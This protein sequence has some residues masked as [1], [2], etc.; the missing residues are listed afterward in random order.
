LTALV[1]LSLLLIPARACDD[2]PT[3]V[4]YD[5]PLA[6]QHGIDAERLAEA[7]LSAERSDRVNSLLVERN[8]VL[9]AEAYFRGFE[10]ESLNSVWS[11]TKSFNSALI[12]IAIDEGYI[13]S[14]DQPVGDFSGF[15]RS[16][17][18]CGEEGDYSP[19]AADHELRVAV[20][21]GG[22]GLGVHGL[23][24]LRRPADIHTRQTA[25]LH[26]R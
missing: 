25:G 20:D 23:D 5:F 2:S 13:E 15:R 11:V 19:P 16:W 4:D 22:P 8:G 26:T 10:P 1:A 18:R 24:G 9:V 12:G 3:S 6:E 21:R 17:T 14:V 7:Y